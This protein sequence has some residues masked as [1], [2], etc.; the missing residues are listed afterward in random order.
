MS[1]KELTIEVTEVNSVEVDDVDFTK[2]C[3]DEV[4]EQFAA[5]A[6]RPDKQDTRLEESLV[7]ISSCCTVVG[8]TCLIRVCTEP[9]DCL[10]N[11][12]RAMMYVISVA[13]SSGSMGEQ[14]TQR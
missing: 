5:N 6:A 9:S 3:E 11:L 1:E 10:G 12:S 13:K 7:I 14:A 2:P 4:L 8:F